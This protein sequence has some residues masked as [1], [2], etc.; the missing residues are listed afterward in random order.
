MPEKS[1]SVKLTL[2]RSGFISG[3]AAIEKQTSAAAQRMGNSMSAVGSSVKTW[4]KDVQTFVKV[5]PAMMSAGNTGWTNGMLNGLKTLESRSLST[6]QRIG[7]A[8]RGAFGGGPVGPTFGMGGKSGKGGGGGG[9]GGAS[10]WGIGFATNAIGVVRDVASKVAM[11]GIE[12]T[13]EAGKTHEAAMQLSV[14]AHQSGAYVDPKQLENEF[15][16]TAS[17]VK[18]ITADDAA[19][20]ATKFV[21]MT[22]DLDTARSSLV[23]FANVS[24][25]T[26]TQM[27]SVAEAVASVS[28]QFKITDPGQLREVMAAMVSQGKKGAIMFNDMAS[29]LQRLAASGAAHGLSGVEGVKTLGGLTQIAKTGTGSPEQAFTAVER[30]MSSLVSHSKEMKA[31]GIDVYEGKGANRHMRNPVAV[32]TDVIRKAGGNNIE[33]KNSL[34]N[35]WMGEEGIRAVNP[36]ITAYQNAFSGLGRG[37]SGQDPTDKER[38]AAGTDALKKMFD[39]AINAGGSWS[40]LMEDSGKMQQ[41]STAA[42]TQAYE[43]LKGKIASGVLPVFSALITKIVSQGNAVDVF[44]KAI[45]VMA[46]MA[47]SLYEFAVKIG[48]VKQYGNQ[49]EVIHGQDKYGMKRTF[50]R[51][52]VVGS[53]DWDMY[54]DKAAQNKEFDRQIAIEKEEGRQKE[55]E[56]L[57]KTLDPDHTGGRKSIAGK[58]TVD[59]TAQQLT[60]MAGPGTPVGPSRIDS[61]TS[62]VRVEIVADRTS[63]PG[64]GGGA[65]GKTVPPGYA[66][67]P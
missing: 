61:I 44:V 35:S 25:G 14:N 63:R 18:G 9:G 54:G 43:E 19:A 8:F 52:D 2:N 50:H 22:G 13:Q 10:S 57:Q 33:K 53:E 47:R 48:A 36:M 24:K 27:E 67:R 23:D 34:I 20:A 28:K 15:Y 5:L 1:A 55:V 66:S 6:A 49:D 30:M 31:A 16:S 4:T 51:E 7:R 41:G 60:G 37:L 26:Q 64:A 38:K 11:K 29:G 17:Q 32:L 59:P 39:D 21:A 42:T 46:D 45:E 3:I 58:P 56:E 65:G 62:T 12:V 40:S